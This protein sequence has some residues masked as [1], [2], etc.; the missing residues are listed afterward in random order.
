MN[1]PHRLCPRPFEWFEIHADGSVFLCCPAWLKRPAGN[2]LTR[3]VEQIWNGPVAIELRKTILNGSFHNCSRR[4]CPHFKRAGGLVA[5]FEDLAPGP[6]REALAAGK[7]LLD[8]PPQKINLCFDPRCNLSCPSCRCG[9]SRLA[10]AEAARVDRIAAM[11]R[12]ALLPRAAEV[13]LSGFGDP[14]AAPGYRALLAWISPDTCP[15]LRAV[16]LHSNGQLFTAE[17]WHKLP[18]LHGLVREV[19]ISVDAACAD[20]YV[21]NRPG[22]DFQRLLDNLEFIARLD[23]R[24]TLSMVVQENNVDEMIGLA[25]LAR[26]LNARCYFSRLV[27]WG[28]FSTEDYRRRAIHLPAHPYH[29]RLRVNLVKLAGLTDVDPGNLTDLIEPDQSSGSKTSLPM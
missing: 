2:L 17:A 18:G 5:P 28:T 1:T 14:F 19:E 25:E 13:T 22:G 10:P 3:S 29:Q 9:Q 12:E 24:L 23:A 15:S 27:N 7:S 26:K 8:F 11:V 21:R 6:A 16:R 4:H 20:T